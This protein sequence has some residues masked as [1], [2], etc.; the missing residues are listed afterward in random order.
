MKLLLTLDYELFLGSHTGTVDNCLIRPLDSY[1]EAV[2]SY[3][4]HFTIFVDAAYLYA[5][6]RQK[7]RFATLNDDYE[8]IKNHLQRLHKGGHD[9]QLHIHPQWFYSEFDGREWHLDTKH[10]KLVDIPHLDCFRLVKES[11]SILDNMIDKSTKVFRAGGFSAQPTA[12]LTDMFDRCGLKVDSSVCPGECYKSDYQ[13][14][15]YRDVLKKINYRFD[16]NICE[17]EE[18]GRFM[19]V[20]LSMYS[21]SPVFHWKLAAIRLLEKFSK[22]TLHDTYGDGQSIHATR[23]SIVHRLIH[24]SNTMAT[25]DGY[26]ISFLKD[27]IAKYDK[28]GYDIMCIIGHPKLA[29]PY[30]VRKMR[31]LCEYAKQMGHEFYTMTEVI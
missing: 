19:E 25:I 12:I 3:G 18:N 15:D 14:Y 6:D 10:Y 16:D 1:L 9:I 31:D 4:V 21:I 24:S 20:P 5:L 2:D 13:R 28:S 11:K 29:T 17:E 27:A 8:K 23:T 7:N 26:K 30:S 22:H